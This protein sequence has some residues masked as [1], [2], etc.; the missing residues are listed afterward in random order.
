MKKFVLAP[1]SFKGTLS[2]RQLCDGMEAVLLRHFPEAQVIRI[3]AADGGEGTVEAFL[4][5][6]GGELVQLPV[7]GPFMGETVEGFFGLLPDGSAVIE[8]AACAALPMVEDRKD[9]EGT[10]TYGVGQ[11]MLAALDRGCRKLYIGLGGSC[12]NDGG[13]GAAAACGA[14]FFDGTGAAFVPTGGTL[15]KIARIDL[16]GLDPRLADTAITVLS[17]V[18]NPL[19]GPEGAAYV[20]GPQKGADPAGVQRLDAGLRNLDAVLQTA[21][22]RS[23]ADLPGAGA[24]G[25]MGAGMTAFFGGKLKSGID[26]LLDAADFENRTA[27]AAA[28]FTGEGRID[29]QSLG[30]KAVIGIAKRA[31]ALGVPV[32]ALVGAAAPGSEAAYDHGVTAIFST[33]R[34]C[35][36]LAEAAQTAPADLEASMEA[37]VRLMKL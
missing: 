26:A 7:T 10:T 34:R 20:F 12:T 2:A 37:I 14:K 11:L 15:A 4:T 9:P 13:C 21:L 18:K 19:Y 25:G 24:A 30:G 6:C 33:C 8:M 23:F 32:I 1:D 5:A 22:G 28:L 31:A 29:S 36:T 27:G 17:D 35:N 3:P 16:S